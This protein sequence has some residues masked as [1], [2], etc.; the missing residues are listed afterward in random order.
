ME[1]TRFVVRVHIHADADVGPSIG[2][3]EQSDIDVAIED[4]RSQATKALEGCEAF[5]RL[6]RLSLSARVEIL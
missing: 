4:L 5:K 1:A 3:Y 6:R 2:K